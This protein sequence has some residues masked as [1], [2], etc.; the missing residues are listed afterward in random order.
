MAVGIM[1]ID[2]GHLILNIGI[3]LHC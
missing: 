3:S 2:T 1:K